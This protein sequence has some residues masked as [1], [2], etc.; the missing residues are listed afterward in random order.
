MFE[1]IINKMKR[2][3]V[4]NTVKAGKG[5]M[6]M[7]M[8]RL[9]LKKKPTWDFVRRVKPGIGK[10]KCRQTGVIKSCKIVE[11]GLSRFATEYFF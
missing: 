10:F 5:S 1:D 4:L 11:S 2:Q 9:K 6:K 8:S 7:H 3:D